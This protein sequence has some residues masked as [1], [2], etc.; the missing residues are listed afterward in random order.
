MSVLRVGIIGASASSG[1]ARDAH[2]PAL[3][4]LPGLA[5]AAVATK[6]RET[7]AAAGAAFGVRV[8][9]DGIALCE[10]PDIDIV[11]V[12]T[13]VP[14]HRGLVLA[15]LA[16]G[17]HVYCEWP[18]GKGGLEAAELDA[19][20]RASGRHAAIGLQ[21]RA[22]PAVL[23]AGRLID[24]GAIGRL[25]SIN[26]S[27][28]TAGF[29]PIVAE[30]WLYLER[31]DN[32][33]N[34]VTIQGAHTLDLAQLLVGEVS[35]FDARV[36]RQFPQILAG[37]ASEPRP[38]Q[39]FD[40]LLMQGTTD[41]GTTVAIEV[42]GGRPPDT[43]FRLELVGDRG[44]IDLL[45]GAPRG[46]QSGRLRLLLNGLAQPIDDGELTGLEDAALH[47]GGIYAALRDDIRVGTSHAP[48][49][50]HALRL[51]RAVESVLRSPP[52]GTR[53]AA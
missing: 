2:V 5:L 25:L 50:A 27:S 49:F 16:N 39:T 3:Q 11:T 48:G 30:P 41:R 17:K 42:A 38:R 26:I 9:D 43:P 14:D 1:W 18:L 13:R 4:A 32:F 34:L 53:L 12:A 8:Y 28:A 21:L 52:D 29:G 44:R 19:A 22:S 31:P 20:A 15:A 6:S 24:E 23:H 46:F 10:D 40:H 35:S 47:V 37:E 33:A 45:G 7:A 51:T 36:S